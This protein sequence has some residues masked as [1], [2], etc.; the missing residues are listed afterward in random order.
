MAKN[1]LRSTTRIGQT[2]WQWAGRTIT[3][4]ESGVV[5]LFI[6][7]LYAQRISPFKTEN[8]EQALSLFALNAGLTA[9]LARLFAFN[10]LKEPWDIRL[11]FLVPA[12]APFCAAGLMLA[13]PGLPQV[14]PAAL[15]L[16][17]AGAFC[18]GLLVTG[19]DEG[20]WED[21]APPSPQIRAEVQQKHRDVLGPVQQEAVSRRLLY[22]GLALLGLVLT[23]P[24]FLTC[25]LLIW[26]EDPGPVFFIKNS[27]GKS[28]M[29]FRQFKFR[30]MIRGAETG[31]GPVMADEHDPRV[32]VCGRF[33]RKSALDEL[34]QLINILRGEM[35]FVGP[36]PQRTV[37][38]HGYLQQ[39]PAYAYRHTVL[40]GLSGLAQVA[41]DY[42]LTPGQKLRF[43]R[44]YIRHASPG[45][46]L[47]LLLLACLIAFWFRWQRDWKGRLPRALLHSARPGKRRSPRSRSRRRLL[48]PPGQQP[49]SPEDDI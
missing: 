45:F 46:D 27:T 13:I 38:V 30:T 2:G 18:G 48:H 9:V 35:S 32:L 17:A 20:L 19:L 44:L 43:D 12:G 31:T 28:G 29:N 36:R 39:N 7:W 41:G 23:G 42:Y 3:A 21:N 33:L 24:I 49:H 14:S 4:V 40:P 10:L 5:I 8:W 16:S 47:K 25:A 26:L 15:G 34:P 37:L 11:A 22:P 6:A 1:Q